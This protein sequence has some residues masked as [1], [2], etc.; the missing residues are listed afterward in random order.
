M[1]SKRLKNSITKNCEICGTGFESW[2]K[3][4]RTCSK[5]CKSELARQITIKQFSTPESRESH[6]IV[7]KKAMEDPDVKKNYKI[8]MSNRRSYKKENHPRW[9]IKLDDETKKKISKGNKG[10]SKGKTWEERYGICEANK[11]RKNTAK[12]MAKTNSRL[13]KRR[14]SKFEKSFLTELKQ[15]G[16]TQNQQIDKYTVDYVNKDTK[17]IIEINGDYWHCNPKHYPPD[18]YNHSIKMFA[19]EKWKYDEDRKKYLEN[20]GYSVTVVWESEYKRKKGIK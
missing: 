14:T 16:Y 4:T 7:T 10:K 3:K 1:G 2:Y 20:L 8:G 6:S 19:S 9:G 13:L 15:K 17:H 18:Y 11:R 5:V 12:R